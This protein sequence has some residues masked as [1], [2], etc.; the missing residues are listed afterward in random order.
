[1]CLS[2]TELKRTAVGP[3]GWGVGGWLG[4]GVGGG[5]GGNYIYLVCQNHSGHCVCADIMFIFA[6]VIRGHMDGH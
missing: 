2:H 6:H 4:V 5:G 3:G 1:M